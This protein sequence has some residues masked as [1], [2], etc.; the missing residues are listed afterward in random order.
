MERRTRQSFRE[1]CRTKERHRLLKEEHRLQSG[2]TENMVGADAALRMRCGPV[3]DTLQQGCVM[4]ASI[5]G[6]EVFVAL[7]E[8][9]LSILNT[10]Y[11]E[12]DDMVRKLPSIDK[13][14][15]IGPIYMAA[16]GVPRQHPDHIIDLACFALRIAH[17]VRTFT[18]RHEM[19]ACHPHDPNHPQ[20]LLSVRIG[21]QAGPVVGAM[22]TSRTRMIYDV[23]GDTVNTASRMC[24]NAP[25]DKIMVTNEFAT[26]L[27]AST[28]YN[29]LR[30]ELQGPTSVVVKGKGTMDTY[31][32]GT[33]AGIE[34]R[35][36]EI[37]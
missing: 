14:K 9:T 13:I 6:L 20:L 8:K 34:M 33:R 35:I 24:S 21:I 18:Q 25:P 1:S 36:E 11:G 5:S 26:L 37:A 23:F 27:R 10:L 17:A 16:G 30:L 19:V 28:R 2:L 12:L 31:L 4:F 29:Q 15:N 32:L 7:P 22:L 3:I